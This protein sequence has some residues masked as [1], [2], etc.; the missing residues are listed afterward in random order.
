MLLVQALV[1]EQGATFMR[2]LKSALIMADLPELVRPMKTTSGRAPGRSVG[3]CVIRF[4]RFTC[5]YCWAAP[6]LRKWM[7][8]SFLG[9]P[10]SFMISQARRAW[11]TKRARPYHRMSWLKA[12]VSMRKRL[13]GVSARTSL[14]TSSISSTFMETCA[15]CAA[16]RL[17]MFCAVDC[18]YRLHDSRML[19]IS[20]EPAVMYCVLPHFRC[21]LERCMAASSAP[22]FARLCAT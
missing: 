20:R 18:R 1:F 14:L 19:W 5:W 4:A 3:T 22:T 15:P 21:S 11:G 13:C 6:R 12:S 16:R 8:M 9:M 7:V 10:S 2:V 17:G